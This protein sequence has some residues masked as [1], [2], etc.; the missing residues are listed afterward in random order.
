M[1]AASAAAAV[2]P[3]HLSP[4]SEPSAEEVL[5][6]AREQFDYIRMTFSDIHGIARHQSVPRRHFEHFIRNGI[7]VY[8]GFERVP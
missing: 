8:A 1:A 2:E 3:E 7:A 6:A 5:S 4:A